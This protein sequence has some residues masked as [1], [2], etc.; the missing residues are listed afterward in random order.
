MR[1]VYSKS[2]EKPEF[3]FNLKT[4]QVE[5][6]KQAPAPDR[7]GPFETEAEARSALEILRSRSAKWLNEE[8]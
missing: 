6:G 8:D 3:W 7:V 5:V 1:S 2:A 4:L